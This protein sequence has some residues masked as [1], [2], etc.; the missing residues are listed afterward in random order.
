MNLDL[1]SLSI[2]AGFF[3]MLI[4]VVMGGGNIL[5]LLNSRDDLFKARIYLGTCITWRKSG[6]VAVPL[7]AG[8]YVWL[9]STVSEAD[10][11]ANP[12]FAE[13]LGMYGMATVFCGVLLLIGLAGERYFPKRIRD[14]EEA[15]NNR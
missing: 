7:T 3:L 12:A 15:S 5:R 1:P 10:M 2:M 13:Q 14:L 9:M 8:P 11:Q 6:M 4:S